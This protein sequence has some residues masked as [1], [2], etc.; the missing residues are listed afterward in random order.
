MDQRFP[1]IRD[2]TRHLF[3]QADFLPYRDRILAARRDAWING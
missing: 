1:R 3:D 2:M